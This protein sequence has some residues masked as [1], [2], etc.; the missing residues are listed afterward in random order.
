MFMMSDGLFQVFRTVRVFL[1]LLYL[2]IKLW[3][4]LNSSND[5]CPWGNGDEAHR[6]PHFLW[7]RF[8]RIYNQMPEV[9]KY[10]FNRR[11]FVIFDYPVW[12][13]PYSYRMWSYTP[14]KTSDSYNGS[15][16]YL[17]LLSWECHVPSMYGSL[18]SSW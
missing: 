1:Y 4:F 15:K 6:F 12:P 13:R 17:L 9:C 11:I 16:N 2:K 5:H 10:L 8:Y 14:P 3:S 18:R 7:F